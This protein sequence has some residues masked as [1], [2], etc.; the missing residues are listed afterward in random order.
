MA[1][2]TH[3]VGTDEYLRTTF[4]HDPELI[5]GQLKE[6]PM[7]TELHAYVQAL[8]GHWFLLHKAEWGVMPLS[9]VRTAVRAGRFRLPDVAVLRARPL[10]N[11][12]LKDPPLIAIEILSPDDSFSDLRDRAQDFA[13]MGTEHIWLIDPEQR[14]AFAWRAE[15]WIPLEQLAVPA[16]P[17]HVDLAWLW[18]Q[19]PSA[20]S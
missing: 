19:V 4:E 14:T 11:N 17:I 8:L 15:A 12:P 6:R 10:N 13:A 3:A 20:E 5:D 2:T 16:T 7:P 9:E 18:S 1:T